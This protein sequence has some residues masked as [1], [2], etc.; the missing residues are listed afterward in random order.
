MVRDMVVRDREREWIGIELTDPFG[1]DKIIGSEP[2]NRF[3]ASGHLFYE[4]VLNRRSAK[5]A[6][7][8]GCKVRSV[9]FHPQC[10]HR[11]QL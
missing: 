1:K 8:S 4:Y 7:Y 10:S 5:N 2:G 9:L 6:G 11:V 3:A